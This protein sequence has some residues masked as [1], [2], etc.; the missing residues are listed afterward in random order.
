MAQEKRIHEITRNQNTKSLTWSLKSWLRRLVCFESDLFA[1]RGWL[2]GQSL[3]FIKN[4]LEVFVMRWP[5]LGWV[6]E[7]QLE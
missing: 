1:R 3:K 2:L 4:D 7:L 6:A 5:P